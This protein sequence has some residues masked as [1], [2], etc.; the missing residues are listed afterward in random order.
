VVLGLE[1]ERVDVD[2]DGRHVRVVLE[3]LDQVE[4]LA[5]AHRE[6]IVAVELEERRNDRVLASEALDTRD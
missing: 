2:A 4:I 6:A 1:G 5:L 3:G